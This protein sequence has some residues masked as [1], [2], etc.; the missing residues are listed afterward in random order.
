LKI[1]FEIM[2]WTPGAPSTT[3]VTEVYGTLDCIHASSVLQEEAQRPKRG[4]RKGKSKDDGPNL[5][6]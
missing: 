1:A 4:G 2:P 6:R 5:L 3:C